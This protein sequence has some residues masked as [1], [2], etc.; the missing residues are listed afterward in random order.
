MDLIVIWKIK[1]QEDEI[2]QKQKQKTPQKLRKCSEDLAIK[3]R[4]II[5]SVLNL[6]VQ[7][8]RGA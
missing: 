3:Q 1:H 7:G 4:E 8:F 5:L 6:K 2:D